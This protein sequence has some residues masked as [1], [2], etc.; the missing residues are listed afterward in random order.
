MKPLPWSYTALEDFV[1]CPRS[2]YEKRVTKSVKEPES[3][4]MIWGTRVHKHFEDRQKDGTP[5]PPELEEHE[6]FMERL[7]AMP[8]EHVTERKIALDKAGKPCGFFDENV[9]FR[10][11]IDYTKRH[12]DLAQIID[13]KT[14]KQHSKFQQLKLFALHTFAEFP[15]VRIVEVKFYWTK[16]QTLTGERYARDQIPQLWS[17]FVPNLKQYAQAFKEDIWQPRPS[18]LCNGWCPVKDCEFWK[19]KRS[20]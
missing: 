3:E 12:N 17:T 6:A 5:L 1:N 11:V 4:Q 13:Y 20:K 14:G 9:W 7:E 16:T 2:Y 8:G 18:G 19:P 15:D 10:G